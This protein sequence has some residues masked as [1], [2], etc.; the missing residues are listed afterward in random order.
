MKPTIESVSVIVKRTELVNLLKQLKTKILNGKYRKKAPCEIT[1]IEGF[2]SF[3][4]PGVSI[5]L[6][7]KTT[8]TAKASFELKYF[9]GILKTFRCAEIIIR[10]EHTK[11]FLNTFSFNAATSFFEDDSILRSVVLPMNFNDLDLISISASNLYTTEELQ[12][13]KLLLL[14]TQA[15][16][17]LKDRLDNAYD[18]LKEYGI[19]KTEIEESIKIKI[20]QKIKSIKNSFNLQ[21]YIQSKSSRKG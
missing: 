19:S 6:P 7:A 11:I 5:A 9:S 8:G 20:Q 16:E 1:I 10:I 4:V 17:R 12:F 2:I 18:E 14:A 21:E 13:N 15:D 3:T